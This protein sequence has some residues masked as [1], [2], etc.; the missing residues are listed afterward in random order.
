M[1]MMKHRAE[2]FVGDL[3]DSLNGRGSQSSLVLALDIPFRV[4]RDFGTTV[5]T[6]SQSSLSSCAYEAG[7][8]YPKYKKVL[9][10]LSAAIESLLKRSGPCADND[11]CKKINN[12]T[13]SSLI[14][15]FLYSIQDDQFDL[16]SLRQKLS[17]NQFNSVK[18]KK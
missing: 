8:K 14:P 18:G 15:L 6:S 16:L 5:M 9:K 17:D 7:Q 2:A 13:K 10:T 4:I 3:K 1:K 11:A 12:T